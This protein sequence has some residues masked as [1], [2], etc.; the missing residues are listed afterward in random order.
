[1][2]SVKGS[3]PRRLHGAAPALVLADEIAQWPLSRIEEM[4]A[5]LRTASGKIPDARMMMIGT[6]PA[7][8]AHPFAIALRD[9]DYSQMHAA[10]ADDPPFQ[11]RTWAKANPGLDQMPDLELAIAREAKAAKR[12]P[13]ALATFR[14]LRLNQGA[15]DTVQSTLLDA[16]T[17]EAIERAA[18]RDGP[19]VWGLDLGTSAAMSAVACYWP[20]TGRLDALAAFPSTPTF[21]ERGLR[22]GVGGLYAE[23]A[24]RGEL[25]EAGGAAIDIS[26]LVGAA[27]ARFGAPS[28]IAADRWR[29]A[30]LR[31]ALTDAGVP[32]AT[33]SS[34]G[35]A[36]RMAPK[37]FDR[38]A[39]PVLRAR[40]RRPCRCCCA[41]R[42]AKR[43]A[44]WT[45][46]ETPS[47]RKAHK[48]GG[49]LGCA[50]TRRRRRFSRLRPAPESSWMH[51][52]G[53]G[54]WWFEPAS[55]E[56]GRHALAGR[57]P[58]CF[59]A[60][61]L[62]LPDVRQGRAPGVRSRRADRARRRSVGARQ[63]ASPLPG[64][65][66][67][68]IARRTPPNPK[69]AHDRARYGRVAKARDR[70]LLKGPFDDQCSK[71]RPSDFGSAPAPE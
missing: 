61:R 20:A 16:G 44:S 10:R 60:R 7:D 6:R 59:Q 1:M 21:A 45:R 54:V 31:D 15:S 47:C 9:A 63:S 18:E 23:C 5:A 37:M 42:W 28:A 46:R 17:W 19:A 26:A 32:L 68:E 67:R 62:P 41:P 34:A 4:L 22:D 58:G 8:P 52:A 36:S 49:A 12:D 38:S 57:S 70:S 24:R 29:D 56:H 14:A 35:R 11:R 69:P 25:I 30:E 51:R 50:T 48:A 53:A 55:P 3:D 40:F 43:A 39:V 64:L 27:L 66:H 2:L 65:S 71:D 13:S 33:L